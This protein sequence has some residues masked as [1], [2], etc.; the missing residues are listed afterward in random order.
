MRTVVLLVNWMFSDP[1]VHK[2]GPAHATILW[3][4]NGIYGIRYCLIQNTK[5]NH[6]NRLF[7][8]LAYNLLPPVPQ[9]TAR[10]SWRVP[11][12]LLA[13]EKK[14]INPSLQRVPPQI[15]KLAVSRRATLQ[16]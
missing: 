8:L 13:E 11:F 16:P 1:P 3:D 15:L 12:E 4:G 9:S 2:G 10:V 5:L 7:S 6:G 14:R